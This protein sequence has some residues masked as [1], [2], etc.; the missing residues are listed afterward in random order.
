MPSLLQKIA[1][2]V[3]CVAENLTYQ[4][5]RNAMQKIQAEWKSEALWPDIRLIFTA[6]QI[7]SLLKNTENNIVLSAQEIISFKV[8]ER[9]ALEKFVSVYA[10]WEEKLAINIKAD[11]KT[12]LFW[13]SQAAQRQAFILA[14]N[15]KNQL[16]IDTLLM[17]PFARLFIPRQ[18]DEWLEIKNSQA[19]LVFAHL[20]NQPEKFPAL[21]SFFWSAW[22]ILY[23]R[24][25]KPNAAVKLLVEKMPI[26]GFFWTHEL[27]RLRELKSN[28]LFTKVDQLAEWKSFEM[29]KHLQHKA[30]NKMSVQNI[31]L[32][33]YEDARQK[34]TERPICG[35]KYVAHFFKTN[36]SPTTNSFMQFLQSMDL[37]LQDA[38]NM[39]PK[40]I[41]DLNIEKVF[42]AIL[43]D[44][45]SK[46]RK[47][48]KQF[49][50]AQSVDKFFI[51]KHVVTKEI[52]L[53]GR[54]FPQ[55]I[56]DFIQPV[57]G[58]NL[59][60]KM[61]QQVGA[62]LVYYV[63]DDRQLKAAPGHG[64]IFIFPIDSVYYVLGSARKNHTSQ[65]IELQVSIGGT[66]IES[67][68][69]LISLQA[70]VQHK[71]HQQFPALSGFDFAPYFMCHR[72]HADNMCYL[73]AIALARRCYTLAELQQIAQNINVISQRHHDKFFYGIYSL[74][75][76]VKAATNTAMLGDNADKPTM[77]LVN[78]LTNQTE[79]RVIFDDCAV[80]GL[81]QCLSHE[82]L[83][84][85]IPCKY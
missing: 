39:G 5:Y 76:V 63:S 72:S 47:L 28:I 36:F 75:S 15:K 16:L 74:E 77:P 84:K 51:K 20:I 9:E 85:V 78:Y 56:F 29:C 45:F 27:P 18:M 64:A 41:T 54:R 6:I 79:S 83:Q 26:D 24:R 17:E 68:I 71:T 43:S 2:E 61:L 48:K 42:K 53:C 52:L 1:K 57:N 46:T 80:A 37:H 44:S 66:I 11:N 25:I 55:K 7:G 58:L 33:S 14:R 32:R 73:T 81:S 19:P 65:K 69:M 60:K 40:K 34:I 8:L 35:P 3:G 38:W 23:M 21:H 13:S 62:R 12:Y 82:Q 10:A 31:W 49:S 50:I 30:L 67:Q 59:Q 4:D 22:I 70:T